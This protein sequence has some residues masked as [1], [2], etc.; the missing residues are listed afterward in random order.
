MVQITLV[1]RDLIN[2][3]VP[4]NSWYISELAGDTIP[5]GIKWSTNAITPLEFLFVQGEGSIFYINTLTKISRW[6]TTSANDRISASNPYTNFTGGRIIDTY[7]PYAVVSIGNFPGISGPY[8]EGDSEKME[9]DRPLM[10]SIA[11]DKKMEMDDQHEVYLM[12][13]PPSNGVARYQVPL[14]SVEWNPKGSATKINGVWQVDSGS[15]ITLGQAVQYPP[16]PIYTT[17]N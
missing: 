15:A 9:A 10:G 1:R 16:F 6:V 14:Q 5:V 13:F 12:Y 17:Q 7:Y 8:L 11:T 3:T 4:N 2:I